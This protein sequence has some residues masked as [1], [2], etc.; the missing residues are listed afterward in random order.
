MKNTSEISRLLST[1]L[2]LLSYKFGREEGILDYFPLCILIQKEVE[3]D[4]ECECVGNK[5]SVCS[6]SAIQYLGKDLCFLL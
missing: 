1:F 4:K 6:N 3:S 2:C 5:L